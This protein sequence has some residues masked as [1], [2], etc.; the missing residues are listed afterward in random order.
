MKVLGLHPIR[1]HWKATT[2]FCVG[3]S[4]T[5][6]K[7]KILMDRRLQE[8]DMVML[9]CVHSHEILEKTHPLWV[10]QACQAKLGMT[11]RVR[12]GSITLD[13]YDAQPL[14]TGL[15]MIR[16]D[17]LIRDDCVCNPLVGDVV[18]DFGDELV[19]NNVVQTQTD[20][21]PPIASHMRW[22]MLAVVISDDCASD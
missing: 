14:G 3:T 22:S 19:V 6:G 21:T 10:S 12:E 16:I 1:L 20:Q 4:T 2:F 5:S 8:S 17:H 9:G 18:I 15:F 11:K 13:D 7:L